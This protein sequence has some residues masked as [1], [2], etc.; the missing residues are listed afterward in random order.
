MYP[1]LSSPAWRTPGSAVDVGLLLGLTD[2]L[3]LDA[4]VNVGVTDA[5]DDV[6]PFVGLA[7]RF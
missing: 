2:H 1:L 7:W 5:A 4:G 3:Q 6:N